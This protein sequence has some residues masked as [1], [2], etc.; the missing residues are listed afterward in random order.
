[1]VVQLSQFVYRL[2][3]R[4]QT[5]FTSGGIDIS[6]FTVIGGTDITVGVSVLVEISGFT[7]GGTTIK[8]RVTVVVQISRLVYRWHY[9][10][11]SWC[12]GGGTDIRVVVAVV[13]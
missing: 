7:V 10:Y 6:G 1:V 12:A 9:I 5:C 2:W 11:H 3:H 8:V 13:V 4:Y